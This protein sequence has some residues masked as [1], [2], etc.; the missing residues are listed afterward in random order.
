[1]L[2]RAGVPG[3]LSVDRG[4]FGAEG[5]SERGCGRARVT[6]IARAANR[7]ACSV[8]A[9]MKKPPGVGPRR[10]RSF[11]AHSTIGPAAGQA[12]ISNGISA[13]IVPLVKPAP[14][15]TEA[16]MADLNTLLVS[17][18]IK[19]DNEKDY[20]AIYKA[21]N[22]SIRKNRTNP[23]IWCESTSFYAVQT[24]ESSEQFARRV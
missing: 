24:P 14:H 21:L 3:R 6:R 20:D 18:D 4:Q 13:R 8:D 2:R 17:F 12:R 9:G 1:M 22:A 7:L 19:Y 10:L 11:C 15:P 16:R 5:Q 23:Q